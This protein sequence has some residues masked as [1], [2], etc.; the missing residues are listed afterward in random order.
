MMNSTDRFLIVDSDRQISI[1]S[2]G[3]PRRIDP[4]YIFDE[5]I[6]QNSPVEVRISPSMRMIFM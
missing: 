6:Q 3:I 2:N 5:I 1:N 4:D